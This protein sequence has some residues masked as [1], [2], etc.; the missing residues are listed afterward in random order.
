M[1]DRFQLL[2]GE[3]ISIEEKQRLGE[4]SGQQK[5]KS[6]RTGSLSNSSARGCFPS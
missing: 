4:I 5:C 1:V 3:S 6:Q 2:D